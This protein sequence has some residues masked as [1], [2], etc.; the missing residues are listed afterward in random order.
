MIPISVFASFLFLCYI[1]LIKLLEV[2]CGSVE[3]S[4]RQPCLLNNG[5]HEPNVTRNH[6]SSIYQYGSSFMKRSAMRPVGEMMRWSSMNSRVC[7]VL[8][9]IEI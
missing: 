7:N 5:V 8:Y 3:L 1:L 4:N 2:D 9:S 6:K